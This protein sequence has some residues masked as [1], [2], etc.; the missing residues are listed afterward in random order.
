MNKVLRTNH[1]YTNYLCRLSMLPS[2]H[3]NHKYAIIDLLQFRQALTTLTMQVD[4]LERIKLG[5]YFSNLES[6]QANLQLILQKTSTI[7]RAEVDIYERIA[8]KGLNDLI[9]EPVCGIEDG[10][11]FFLLQGMDVWLLIIGSVTK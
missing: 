1:V 6:E 4:E 11:I 10:P 9:L 2:F 5:Y 8:N 3:P 7:V